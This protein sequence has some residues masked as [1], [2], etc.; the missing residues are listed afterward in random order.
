MMG[1]VTQLSQDYSFT[2]P[3]S[4]IK[5]SITKVEL[6]RVHIRIELSHDFFFSLIRTR[7]QNLA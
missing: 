6:M 5:T 4:H 7:I 3:R 2:P 1:L